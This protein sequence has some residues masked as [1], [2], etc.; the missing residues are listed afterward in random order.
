MKTHS[1]REHSDEELK[2]LRTETRRKIFDLRVRKSTG[3]ATDQPLLIRTV[4]RDLARIL[5]VMKERGLA[6]HG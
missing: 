6:K 3:E 4:R 1:I 2:Q 5:T